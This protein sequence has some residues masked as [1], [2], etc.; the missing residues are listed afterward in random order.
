MGNVQPS[1]QK[2]NE[3][4]PAPLPPVCDLD[5][6]RKKDLAVLTKNLD[7]ATATKSIDPSKYIKARNA[8]YTFVEGPG[9][10]DGEREKLAKQEVEPILKQYSNRFESLK[11]EEESQKIFVNLADAIKSKQD[12]SGYDQQYLKRVLVSQKNQ[13][14]STD[15]LNQLNSDF[16]S[17]LPYLIDFLIIGIVLFACVIAITKLDKIKSLLGFSTNSTPIT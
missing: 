15:R 7:D 17:Y 16:S 6:Q 11:K 8:Y 13:A 9:W 12:N 2:P 10:I 1:P 3:T 14:D 5:C 4:P